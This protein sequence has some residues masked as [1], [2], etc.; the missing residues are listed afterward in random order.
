MSS[1]QMARKRG[2]L[3]IHPNYNFVALLISGRYVLPRSSPFNAMT[4]MYFVSVIVYH[5]LSA[6]TRG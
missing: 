4:L 2:G 5:G 1:L 6:C 3:S